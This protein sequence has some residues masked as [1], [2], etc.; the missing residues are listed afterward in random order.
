MFDYFLLGLYTSE[1]GEKLWT[2]P[3]YS[4][5][6]KINHIDS[7]CKGQPNTKKTK[8]QISSRIMG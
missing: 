5:G 7:I 1:I 3:K 2:N 6:Q 8:K 4:C